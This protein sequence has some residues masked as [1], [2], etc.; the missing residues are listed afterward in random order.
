MV[1]DLTAGSG[2][3]TGAAHTPWVPQGGPLLAVPEQHSEPCPADRQPLL[4]PTG[5]LCSPSVYIGVSPTAVSFINQDDF[6]RER[7]A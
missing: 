3:S 5:S 1:P 6:Q 7:R 4:A 2:G